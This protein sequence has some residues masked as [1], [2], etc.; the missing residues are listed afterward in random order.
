MGLDQLLGN[1]SQH[2]SGNKSL[3]VQST[4]FFQSFVFLE[5][6]DNLLGLCG[7]LIVEYKFC[8]LDFLAIDFDFANKVESGHPVKRFD[9][10]TNSCTLINVHL[11]DIKI[12][13]M[14]TIIHH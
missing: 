13:A 2:F 3:F 14:C 9:D 8:D 12:T 10:L 5:Y 4:T 7:F 1:I 6:F 11:N